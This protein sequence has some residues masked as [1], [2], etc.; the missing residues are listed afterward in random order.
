MDYF[1]PLIKEWFFEKVGVPT[2]TQL[3]AWEKISQGD[4]VLIISPTGSGKTLS[5]FLWAIN[6][7]AEGYYSTGSTA[8]LYISPLKALN[9]DIRK[10]LQRPLAELSGF[11]EKRNKTFPVINV[12]TR[13]GDTPYN[14]RRYFLKHPPEILVTTPES[15][16]IMLSSRGGAGILSQVKLVVFDEI[17]AIAGS[18]RGVYAMSAIERLV[19]LAGDFQRV[20]LSATVNPPSI[21]ADFFG[22]YSPVIYPDGECDFKKR[23]IETINIQSKKDYSIEIKS[24][25][26]DESDGSLYNRVAREIRD[27]LSE[28]SS[29]LLFGNSRKSAE[30]IAGAI[31]EDQQSLAAYSHHGSLS[32]ELRLAVEEKLKNGELKAIAATNTLELGIDIGFVDKVV[33]VQTPFTLSSAIQKIGRAGHGVGEISK[34]RLLTSGGS[35]LIRSVAA[36]NCILKKEI[37]PLSIP[38]CPLDVLSQIIMS[39]CAFDTV[40]IDNVFTQ[41]KSMYAYRNLSEKYYRLVLDMLSGK[42]ESSRIREFKP[43]LSVDYVNRTITPLRG[44]QM[45][46]FMSGGVIPD[47]GYYTVR[48][49]HNGDRIGELDEEFVWERN[50]G[51]SFIIGTQLW[52]IV[53]VDHNN[54]YVEQSGSGA[55]IPFWKADEVSRDYYF[56]EKICRLLTRLDDLSDDADSVNLLTSEYSIDAAV[57]VELLDFCRKQ[58]SFTGALP[59]RYKII[60]EHIDDPL[61]TKDIQ[62]IVVHT[63]W[64]KKVNYPLA[65][66]LVSLWKRNYDMLVEC[67]INN[68]SIIMVLPK[69]F[70]TAEIFIS[71]MNEDIEL[72]LRDY[73]ETT[74]YFAGKF[75]ENAS[76][77]MLLPKRSFNNRTPFWLTRLKSKKLFETVLDF[78]DFP[79]LLET[80]RQCFIDDFDLENL[81]KLLLEIHDGIIQVSEVI[82]HIP[83]PMC[84]DIIWQTINKYMYQDD[85]PDTYKKSKITS[86]IFSTIVNSNTGRPKILQSVIDGFVAKIQQLEDGYFPVNKTEFYELVK[87]RLAISKSEWSSYLQKS[88]GCSIADDI[89]LFVNNSVTEIKFSSAVYELHFLNDNVSLIDSLS[90]Y[91]DNDDSRTNLHKVIE[92]FFC[93]WL[94]YYG[95]ISYETISDIFGFTD[96]HFPLFLD[97]MIESKKVIYDALIENDDNKYFCDIENYERLLRIKRKFNKVSVTP[98]PLEYLQFYLAMYNDIGCGSTSDDL[99][100]TL[101]KLFGYPAKPDLWETE[102][103]PARISNYK[104]AWLDEIFSSTDISWFGEGGKTI[105]FSFMDDYDLFIER[106]GDYLPDGNFSVNEIAAMKNLS[107]DKTGDALW[108]NALKGNVNAGSFSF[109]RDKILKNFKNNNNNHR[110]NL[111][112]R[113]SRTIDKTLWRNC[114]INNNDMLDDIE[115]SKKRVRQLIHRYGILTRQLFYKELPLLQ[116]SNIF[117]VLKIMELSGEIISGYFFEDIDSLQFMTR[118][119]IDFFMKFSEKKDSDYCYFLNAADPVS[120]CS[121]FEKQSFSLFP[122]RRKNNVMFFSGKN[123]I[124]SALNSFKQIN[125]FV[126]ANDPILQRIIPL[127]KFPL[128][129]NFNP[130]KIITIDMINGESA[131]KSRYLDIFLSNGWKVCCQKLELFRNYYS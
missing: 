49:L 99:K 62:Q 45:L 79:I 105:S 38:E 14:E 123:I 71:L 83:S 70:S 57:A 88:E 36:V 56:S 58:K 30:K 93:N 67:F 27:D 108:E 102:I 6:N 74:G 95:P 4:S 22:G 107:L 76:R 61:N 19:F 28:N 94:M 64:G 90:E 104:T 44:T 8:I 54:V 114:T 12:H 72:L 48:L 84:S 21:I 82:T 10:N 63:F 127:I 46:L 50:I 11:F 117:K 13:S 119:N 112:S 23:N 3:K 33:L 34:A 52:R 106:N 77:A 122:S 109:V 26:S 110:I 29:V 131:H 37:E 86:D 5:A 81:K 24:V 115:L 65:F 51:D 68:D 32:K 18:K 129:R 92:S 101:E 75:R 120:L 7:F 80:W 53:K 116:W 39:I 128:D 89:R 103:F 97:M 124:V 55:M 121:V 35:D 1:H 73:L 98:L 15:L 16:N 20:A 66:A 69:T 113:W 9:N 41:L 25:T 130:I 59:G 17:H 60:I 47:R 125:I 2:D 96:T 31:N 91:I 118:S 87:N 43:R 126:E 100:N 78:E 40:A 42:Y 111:N 85:T